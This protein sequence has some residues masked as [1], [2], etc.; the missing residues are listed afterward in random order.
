MHLRCPIHTCQYCHP[1]ERGRRVAC[2]GY[3]DMKRALSIQAAS[4]AFCS[5]VEMLSLSRAFFVKPPR[6][7]VG[8]THCNRSDGFP[9]PMTR[10]TH[11]LG[12]PNHRRAP[13]RTLLTSQT[14]GAQR[15]V[16]WR[17]RPLPQPQSSRPDPAG[18]SWYSTSRHERSSRSERMLI[19]V[20]D[21]CDAQKRSGQMAERQEQVLQAGLGGG[22]CIIHRQRVCPLVSL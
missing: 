18:F 14:P 1:G 17:K 3:G 8:G 12:C 22:R 16:L 15:V 21:P 19:V 13:R 11:G 9:P 5:G 6:N 10:P 2:T 7:T 20:E 4:L